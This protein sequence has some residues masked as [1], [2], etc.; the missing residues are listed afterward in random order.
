MYFLLVQKVP[1][2]HFFFSMRKRNKKKSKLKTV[3]NSDC[4]PLKELSYPLKSKL[5][6]IVCI[7]RSSPRKLSY[8]LRKL[9]S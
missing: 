6:Q 3:E 7:K 4:F 5:L 8:S 1:K 2:I 9:A